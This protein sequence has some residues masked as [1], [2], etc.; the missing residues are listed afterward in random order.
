MDDRLV[1]SNMEIVELQ[2]LVTIDNDVRCHV[3]LGD[4]QRFPR[5][6]IFFDLSL[7]D[8]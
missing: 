4:F 1:L 2:F 8:I 7:F 6:K 3:I 5:A